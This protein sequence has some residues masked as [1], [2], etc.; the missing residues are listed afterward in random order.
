MNRETTGS[1]RVGVAST[2][3]LALLIGPKVANGLRVDSQISK[4]VAVT[5]ETGSS[6]AARPSQQQ[7][8]ISAPP[9][10]PV[11]SSKEDVISSV[12]APVPIVAAAPAPAPAPNPTP[13]P[14]P[15]PV[16]RPSAD[17]QEAKQ[18]GG[19]DYIQ[20]MRD[21]G[22][23]LDLNKDLDTLVSMRSIGVTPEYAK[24]MAGVGLGT[25][26][27]RDLISLKAVGVTPEYVAE[28]RSSGIPPT[29]FREVISERSLGITPEY[30][31]SVSAMGMGSPTVHDLVSLKSQGITPEY[32]ATLRAAGINP[33]D[34]HELTSLKA[35]GVTP[36]FAKGMTDAG[37]PNLSTH[38]LVSLRAQG[39]TPEY[40]RWLKQTFHDADTHTL[41]QASVFH[42]DADFVAKAKAHGF[43]N[44]SI[45]KLVKLKMT[46]LLD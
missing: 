8:G 33:K 21:A 34:L 20:K 24:A 4:V 14:A 28:L 2:V 40:A 31:K 18:S 44:A 15:M 39:V 13:A 32:L 10:E 9:A 1:I 35:V 27:P 7:S 43:D 45:D 38:D 11:T 22:Y 42:V 17:P 3:L 25:P 46:G 16:A 37:Y 26:A 19:A 5:T 36:E 12:E 6:P 41:R 29:T 23:P 30:A